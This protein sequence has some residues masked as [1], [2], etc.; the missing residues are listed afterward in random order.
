MTSG[1]HLCLPAD[2]RG[3][4][5]FEHRNRDPVART[6]VSVWCRMLDEQCRKRPA[7]ATFR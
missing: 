7:T 3:A 1:Q 6:F 5:S 2:R 4:R